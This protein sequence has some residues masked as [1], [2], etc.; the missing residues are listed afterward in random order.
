MKTILTDVDGVL[1][2]WYQGFVNWYNTTYNADI[3]CIPGGLLPQFGEDRDWELRVVNEFNSLPYE[4]GNL[5]VFEDAVHAVRGLHIL[6]WRF[7]AITACIN[8]P[9]LWNARWNQLE[10]VFP[11]V[12]S[13]L[14]HTEHHSKCAWLKNYHPTWWIEDTWHNAQLGADAGHSVLFVDRWS[15]HQ[16]EDARIRVVSSWQECYDIITLS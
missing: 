6:G 4:F 7:V 14:H 1:L 9:D 12:F 5:P 3:E 2:N 16:Q 8:T 13:E 15:G 10:R 11:G